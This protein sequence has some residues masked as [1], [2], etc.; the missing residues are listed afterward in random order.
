MLK[1]DFKKIMKL[2]ALK[3]IELK[4][5]E[6]PERVPVPNWANKNN[7][8]DRIFGAF[9]RINPE[10]PC[11]QDKKF[12][13]NVF[14]C[15]KSAGGKDL[16]SGNNDLVTF[17]KTNKEIAEWRAWYEAE[18]VAKAAFRKVHKDEIKK[19]ND[20]R[21]AKYGIA[22]VN[23]VEE[24]LQSWIVEP[25]G[26]FFGR[27]DSPINGL[28]KIETTPSDII[29]NT[30]SKNL[31]Q[32]IQDKKV[33]N[34][35]DWK[36]EWNPDNHSAA[37]YNLNIGIPDAN[38]KLKTIKS[39]KYKMIAFGANSSIKKEGQSKK[40]AAASELANVS[41]KLRKAVNE[42]CLRK[43]NTAIALYILMNKG[44][45][46]GSPEATQNGTKG[47]LSLEFGKDVKE[48]EKG[49][50]FDFYGKD[51]V[52]DTTT[53]EIKDSKIKNVIIDVWKKNKKLKTSRGEIKEFVSK[54]DK[55]VGKVFTP[56]LIRTMVAAE[57]MQKALDEVAI[58]YKLSKE[59]P[60][61]LKKLAFDEANMEVAR[62]LNH[63]RGVNKIAEKKREEANKQKEIALKE[64]ETKIKELKEKRLAKIT[65]L[66][67]KKDSKDKIAKLKE[68]IKKADERLLQN[69]RNLKFKEE[70]GNI[71][72]ATSKSA[73]IDP[74][75][76]KAF[77]DKYKLP[78]EKIYSK[79]Q[80][81]QFDQFFE[82]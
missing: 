42:A 51:S 78:I 60:D 64:R 18:K 76:C 71:T 6:F 21:K 26:I 22:L 2:E 67:D 77:C 38:G 52:R 3:S 68:Q 32:I 47:L 81:K 39:T 57:T 12:I 82:N 59:S 58:K 63:Q 37:V 36:V 50:K 5:I 49:L 41:E 66:K 1:E 14:I 20:E 16:I 74:T 65:E 24:P 44:I 53:L 17:V 62:K 30:N 48:C 61:A 4:A 54:V 34:K 35:T 73:Y 8:A 15:I 40:Y 9:C 43:S 7:L 80:L 11:M 29:I 46:I 10:L 79:N 27:G 56:K 69:K 25:E 13:K 70:N 19:E 28:W 72:A 33:S 23:G 31:P 75:I 45:R 55:E